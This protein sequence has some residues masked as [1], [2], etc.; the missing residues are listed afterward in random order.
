MSRG[1]ISYGGIG[2]YRRRGDRGEEERRKDDKESMMHFL[3][4]LCFGCYPIWAMA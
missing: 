2:R 4:P 1:I 3:H